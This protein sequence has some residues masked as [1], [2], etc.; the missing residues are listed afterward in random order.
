MKVEVLHLQHI[1]H[2]DKQTRRCQQGCLESE[3]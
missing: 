1:D 2:R 3:V